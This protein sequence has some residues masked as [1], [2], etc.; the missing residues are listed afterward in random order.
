MSEFTAGDGRDSTGFSDPVTVRR[1][2]SCRRV[3]VVSQFDSDVRAHCTSRRLGMCFQKNYAFDR[4][5]VVHCLVLVRR[6]IHNGKDPVL[7]TSIL[8]DHEYY[9][10]NQG[11]LFCQGVK[12]R[13]VTVV[14]AC[15]RI[16]RDYLAVRHAFG[17]TSGQ[18]GAGRQEADCVYFLC[19]RG[20]RDVVAGGLGI[21]KVIA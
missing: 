20:R 21:K 19:A 8:P 12:R 17:P 13:P 11:S 15:S 10:Q 1:L 2:R 16:T 4:R 5:Y 6:G 14:R 9:Q 3:T 18:L 7:D